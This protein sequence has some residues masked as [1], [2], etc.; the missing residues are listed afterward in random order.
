[1]KTCKSCKETKEESEFTAYSQSEDGLRYNCRA[2]S[3]DVNLKS[4]YGITSSDREKLINSQKGI[5]PICEIALVIPPTN[6]QDGKTSKISNGYAV[7]DHDHKTNLIRGVLCGNCN[8]ML[9]KAKDSPEL[10]QRA[11]NYLMKDKPNEN[12]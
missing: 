5:C 1:M 4:K 2:C 7:I 12:A 6:I 10:L 11:I 9:G 8:T 3:I